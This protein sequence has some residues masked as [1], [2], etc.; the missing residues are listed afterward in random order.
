MQ[1]GIIQE[2]LLFY[3]ILEN[4]RPILVSLTFCIFVH[5]PKYE[6]HGEPRVMAWIFGSNSPV[7]FQMP[8]K[9]LQ[10]H[11]VCGL[12]KSLILKVPWSVVSHL[13]WVL[14]LEKNFLPCQKHIKMLEVEMNGTAIYHQRQK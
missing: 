10:V 9:I 2:A 12:V 5:Y 7:Q 13:P 3:H 4:I 6:D 8:P 14:S 11:V 1:T